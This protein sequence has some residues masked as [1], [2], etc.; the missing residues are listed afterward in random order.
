MLELCKHIGAGGPGRTDT[1][2]LTKR[3]LCLLSFTGMKME[4]ATGVEPAYAGIQSRCLAVQPR[5]H[6]AQ[7]RPRTGKPLILRQRGIPIPFICAFWWTRRYRNR[8]PLLARQVLSQLSYWPGILRSAMPTTF[9]SA[10]A[11]DF[12]LETLHW[13]L[14]C[15]CDAPSKM[16]AGPRVERGTETVMSRSGR[17]ACPPKMVW[18]AGFEPATSCSQG[19]RSAQAELC[20]AKNSF[21]SLTLRIFT[22]KSSTG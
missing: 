18:T 15:I 7:S 22:S 21:P 1:L 8:N 2:P 9:P 16:V 20:P 12:C 14:S 10:A 13:R 17:R 19:R 6:G 4:L 5:Q 3:L 11:S